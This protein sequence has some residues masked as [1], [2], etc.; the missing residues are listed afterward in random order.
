MTRKS[1]T[2]L[3]VSLVAAAS[4]QKAFADMFR[5]LVAHGAIGVQP[6][7]AAAFDGARVG[8]RPI[9]HIDAAHAGEFERAMV[10]LR[11]QRDDEIEIKPLPFVEL[12]EG[13]RFMA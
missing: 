6:L 11:C 1:T 3:A 2:A 5:K 12:F 4:R 9:F 7:H 10:R 13:Y 8:G